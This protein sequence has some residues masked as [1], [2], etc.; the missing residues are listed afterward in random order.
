MGHAVARPWFQRLLEAVPGPPLAAALLIALGYAALHVLV[1]GVDR[2]LQA[3]P[4][5]RYPMAGWVGG[6]AVLGGIL[7]AAW[8]LVAGF[9]ADLR[10]LRPALPC[11]EDEFERL[12]ARLTRYPLRGLVAASLAAP[13]VPALV[14]TA[15]PDSQNVTRLLDAGALPAAWGFV[16]LAL[17]WAI[18]L[19]GLY[20]GTL[21]VVRMWRMGRRRVRVDLVD[22]DALT[23]FGRYGLRLALVLNL[24]GGM[25]IALDVIDTGELSLVG[26]ALFAPAALLGVAALLV[27]SWGLHRRIRQAKAA[28]LARVRSALA[29]DRGALDGSPLRA[30]ADRLSTLDLVQWR[31]RVASLREWP[32]DAGVL[33]RFG[34]YLLIPVASWIAAA[35]VERLVDRLL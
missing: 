22:L 14:V 17:C 11:P 31:D 20:A 4:G 2:W 34:L 32:F 24:G 16:H 26:L 25:L 30:D 1:F 21:S 9:S 10:A 8:F 15:R 13:L 28:E 18:I 33:R 29:G 6:P 23:A 27:P 12:H 35:L 5:F 19:P 3:T 7:W